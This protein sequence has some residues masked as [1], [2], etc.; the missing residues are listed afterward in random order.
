MLCQHLHTVYKSVLTKAGR[1]MPFLRR[2]FTGRRISSCIG[3]SLIRPRALI[4]FLF[5]EYCG[6]RDLMRRISES[7]IQELYEYVDTSVA[8]REGDRRPTIVRT[9]LYVFRSLR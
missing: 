9:Y 3:D 1:Q 6:I 7:L 5:N 2:P 4:A 8:W